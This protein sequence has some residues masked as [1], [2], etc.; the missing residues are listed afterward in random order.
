M[1]GYNLYR[2][3]CR[4]PGS[5]I[6]ILIA[7]LLCAGASRAQNCAT[8]PPG[9]VSWWP[10]NGNAND[11]VGG[12]PG[13]ITTQ[14]LGQVLFSEGKVG[15]AFDF[16]G[17]N[18]VEI[19]SIPLNSFTLEFWLNQRTR[20]A[21]PNIGSTLVSAEVCGVVATIGEKGNTPVINNTAY[22]GRN[23]STPDVR[24]CISGSLIEPE[25]QRE[26]IQRDGWDFDKIRAA[27]IKCRADPPIREENRSQE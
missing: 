26:T 14:F 9:L 27:E 24:L 6:Q 8:A 2:G 19:P 12:N 25:F 4:N 17:A 7:F 16:R 10:G 3:V 11:L 18:F 15:T 20:N 21:E 5:G 23:Q 22:F 1:W 13:T